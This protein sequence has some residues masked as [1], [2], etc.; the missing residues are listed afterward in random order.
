MLSFLLTLNHSRN[1]LFDQQFKYISLFS[2]R[3]NVYHIIPLVSF[4]KNQKQYFSMC[5]SQT[6]FGRKGVQIG[7]FQPR[8]V[9]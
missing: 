8:Y 3:E 2:S 4:N 6:Y 1:I 5:E 9:I 7:V